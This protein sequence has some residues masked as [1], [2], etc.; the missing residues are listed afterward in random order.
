MTAL[1]RRTALQ[2]NAAMALAATVAAAA[3]ISLVLTQPASLGAAMARHEYGA[4]ALAV[5][6]EL[7]GWL[8]ALLHFV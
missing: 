8:S 3:I 5:A 2:V 1:A 6:R 4:I 7:V